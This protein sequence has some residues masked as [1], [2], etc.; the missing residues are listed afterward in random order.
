MMMSKSIV[1]YSMFRATRSIAKTAI[2]GM[3][4][5]DYNV[6]AGNCNNC[7]LVSEY[8]EHCTRCG[9]RMFKMFRGYEQQQQLVDDSLQLVS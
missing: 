4:G 8:T 3:G 7:G 2:D 9:S 1:T 5:V 6:R